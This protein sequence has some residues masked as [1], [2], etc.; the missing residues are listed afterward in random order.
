MKCEF[1]IDVQLDTIKFKLDIKEISL[2]LETKNPKVIYRNINIPVK[3][4]KV[5]VLVDELLEVRLRF[6]RI[7]FCRLS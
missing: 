4:I 6:S 3:N 5:Y 2:F 7:A 1:N